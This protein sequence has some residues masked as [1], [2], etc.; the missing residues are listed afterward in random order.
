MGAPNGAWFRGRG[1]RDVGVEQELDALE[2]EAMMG[3]EQSKG[4]YSMKALGQ[5]VL[6][7]ATQKFVG[8]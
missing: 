5:D 6:E 7:E 8:R 4:S 2:G 1:F 3:V